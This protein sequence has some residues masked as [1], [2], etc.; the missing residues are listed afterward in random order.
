MKK[1]FY[2]MLGVSALVL[3]VL[4]SSADNTTHTPI[5]PNTY[6]SFQTGCVSSCLKQSS[7]EENKVKLYC[8]CSCVVATANCEGVVKKHQL[9]YEEQLPLYMSEIWPRADQFRSCLTKAGM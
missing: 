3:V 7:G 5:T 6:A 2:I 1:Q 8:A 4:P 9:Q